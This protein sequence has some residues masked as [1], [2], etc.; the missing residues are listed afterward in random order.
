MLAAITLRVR[1]PHLQVRVLRSP[2]LGVIGVG[3]GSTPDFPRHLHSY[4][5]IDPGEFLR[6][7]RPSWKLGIRFEWGSR[8]DHFNYGFRPAFNDRLADAETPAGCGLGFV[9]GDEG[10]N[11]HDSVSA[12]MEAGKVFGRNEQG[13][14]AHSAL[15]YH[16]ENADLVAW[17]EEH[18]RAVGAEILDGDLAEAE[19]GPEGV[20]AIRTQSGERLEADLFLDA[21]GFRA[22][23]IGRL[24]GEPL[25]SYR[26]SLLCDR[27]LVGG[28]DRAPGEPVLPYTTATTMDHG[29]CWRIDHHDRVHRGYVYS[30]AFASDEEAERE[31]RAAEPRLGPLRVVPFATGRRR[32]QWSGNVFAV[33]NAAG[34]VEPLEA[35]S[36][37]VICN[38]LRNL[39]GILAD[40]GCAP[41]PGLVETCN[42]FCA[43]SWDEIRDFL[44]VHYR[45][46]G[47]KET[48]FWRACRADTALH[49]AEAV[50][51]FYREN[52]PSMLAGPELLRPRQAIFGLSGYWTLLLGQGVPHGR[53]DLRTPAL[54]RLWQRYAAANAAAAARGAT[55]EE[56]FPLATSPSFRWPPNFFGQG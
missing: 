53:A 4:L 25:V 52:G 37:L 17:L 54:G 19:P 42:R 35:T 1:L 22:E 36:L 16:I 44:A 14:Q 33:G 11:H 13:I 49:G 23:L 2:A 3:E 9:I 40:S 32:R 39:C 20:A 55:I 29:W 10:Y 56:A 41:T 15:G 43:D 5:R 50:V 46:N 26:D 31:F 30:S 45:F 24:R 28:W 12:L 38:E 8:L 21:S 34:F 47:R 48:P 27:A 18:A 7:V 6:R 51:G